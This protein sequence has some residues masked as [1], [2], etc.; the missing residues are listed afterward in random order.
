MQDQDCKTCMLNQTC[1]YAYI[2]E[3]PKVNGMNVQ[4]QAANLPH[5]FVIEPP[6]TKQAEFQAG[7]EFSIG[8]VLFGNSIALLPYFVYTFDQMG[9]MGLGKGRG[10]FELTTVA[11][12]DA[13]FDGNEIEV[14]N[15]QSQMLNGNFKTWEFKD[16]L[17]QQ[18]GD[19]PERITIN[20]V[21]PLRILDKNRLVSQLPFH[22]LMRNILRRISL[23]GRIH[24]GSDWNLPYKDILSQ[25]EQEVEL[26]DSQ[27]SWYSWE[28]Y[29]N[30]QRTRM[31]MGGIIGS[32]TY[33]GNITPFLPLI[34]LGQFTHIGKNTTFGLGKYFLI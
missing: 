26:V 16:L 21:T 5:P 32:L 19:N 30:R 6:V 27:T 20:L 9:R 17:S 15:S 1:P 4:H 3:T 8:L 23:L 24:C 25:A 10:K 18:P 34:L 2:F 7:D 11:A 22:L 33:Q 29:S 31:N 14:Y 12:R 28:R 13:I